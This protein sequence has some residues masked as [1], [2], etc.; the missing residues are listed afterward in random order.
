M[1]LSK[2]VIFLVGIS[3][4]V[5]YVWLPPQYV[6]TFAGREGSTLYVTHTHAT[7]VQLQGNE[8][9]LMCLPCY[10]RIRKNY[11]TEKFTE[12]GTNRIT[13]GKLV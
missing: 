13:T 7:V 5:L 6:I 12:R 10:R 9:L 2:A 4:P 1:K 8:T 3:K 11:A